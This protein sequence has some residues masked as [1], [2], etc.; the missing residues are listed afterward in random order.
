MATGT[1]CAPVTRALGV[2]PI[3]TAGRYDRFVL[4]E[5]PMPWPADIDDHPLL[6]EV[7]ALAATRVLAVCGDRR[8]DGRIRVTRWTRRSTNVLAGVDHLL[9]AATALTGI[10]ALAAGEPCIE[11]VS[12]PAPPDVL[13][14]AH[15]RRDRC[16]GQFGT[17]LQQDVEHRWPGVRVRRCSHTGGHR[18]APTGITLP[19]GRLWAN[20]D[21]TVLDQIVARSGNPAR[22]EAHDRGSTGLG[23]WAQ[24]VERALFGHHGWAWL[25]AEVDAVTEQVDV[26]GRAATIELAWRLPGQGRQLTRARVEIG[27]DVAVPICGDPGAPATKTSTE[28]VLRDLELDHHPS[29]QEHP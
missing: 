6:A 1:G 27:R 13:L 25:D 15:G 20:L 21:E 12:G 18:F 22:L 7:G 3:G 11:S 14:C 26:D 29:T 9:E 10:A 5:T 16:C 19:D 8:D 24:P 4:V 17:R 28:L 2:D 23:S